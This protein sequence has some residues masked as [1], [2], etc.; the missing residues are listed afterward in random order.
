[1]T[2]IVG[3][4]HEGT[5]YI[6]G[7]SC[8]SC[9]QMY[10]ATY[11]NKVFDVETRDDKF[12]IG[13]TGTVRGADILTYS[14]N[15]TRR[16]KD[17]SDDKYMKTTVAE[18]A[19]QAFNSCGHASNKDGIDQNY[20][21]YLIGYNGHLYVMASDYC[22]MSCPD[23]NAI[24]SGGEVALGSLWTTRDWKDPKKRIMAALEAAEAVISSVRSPMYIKEL[25]NG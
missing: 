5:I 1:M 25:K 7:D 15:P 4:E 2:C 18:T 22:I 16:N 17:D 12:L 11:Q 6:G 9:G 14:F 19:R 3:L 20:G 8:T 10:T 23:G 13:I 21:E 24:G